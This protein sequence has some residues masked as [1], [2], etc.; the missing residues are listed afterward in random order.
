M[1]NIHTLIKGLIVT[2]FLSVVLALPAY[3]DTN[4]QFLGDKG[5][6]S[7][8]IPVH[9]IPL[10]DEDGQKVS[11]DDEPLLPFSPRQTCGACHNCDEI[12]RGWHFNAIDAN[13]APGRLGQPWILVDAGT[14]TQVPLS[15][16]S[17]RGAFKPN[18]LGLTTWKFNQLFGRHTP[19]GGPG[20]LESDNPDEVVRGF[21]SGKLEINCLSCH[22]AAPAHDQAEFAL[23]IARQNFRWAAAATCGF[24]SVSGS[25]KSM[26]DTYDPLMPEVLDDPKLLPPTINYR[27][28]TFD[29]KKRVFFNIVRKVP[30][31]RCYFC[32]SNMDLGGEE[33]E[34]WSTDEDVHLAAGLTCVDCHRNGLDHN[35]TRG[36]EGEASVSTN[37]LATTS[38]C[39]GCHLG[40]EASSLPTGGRLA[41]PE[42]R[43]AG[44][45]P[46][47]FDKLTCSACHS[48]TWP[49]QQTVRTKTSRA[50]GLGTYS[51]GKSDDALPHIIY[52]VF[53]KQADG[54]IAPHKLIWP[55][56]W[57]SLKDQEVTPIDL[58][59]VRQGAGIIANKAL[60][61]YG[62]W[63]SLTKE[64]VVEGLALASQ[65]SID[66][67]PIYICG[68]K[69]YRL[70][71]KG[72]LIV[73]EHVA[74]NPYL[75]AVAHDV[76]PAAQSLGIAGCRDCH[77]THSPFFFGEVEIDAPVAS[78]KSSVKK[79]IAFQDLNPVY[80]KLFA[81]SFIFRPFLKVVALGSCAVLGV[82]LLLYGLRALACIVR[83][84]SEN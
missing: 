9:L 83:V 78:E 58:E 72:K 55:A 71:G 68:G 74:A 24:A 33:A 43:H 22:D 3:A 17:W 26:P 82:V 23:Q 73:T 69:L 41:A 81:M 15:Y 21:I 48:G 62:D 30:A 39:K 36:Y 1:F 63:P 67:E 76:R 49:R 16:R 32:H 61:R 84:L 6:G 66:G 47:H 25:A 79:M 42:P 13:I 44:I 80:T 5:D 37:L 77:S 14:G 60:P 75:W 20:E 52:P 70:D 64:S 29:H 53:A 45:P 11:P 12:D 57:G 28:N 7:R 2:G 59:I 35:I 34:K 4:E 65:G 51:V 50:H 46:I 54:K 8:S 56:F 10:L 18:Q 40:G 19:G 38:S 31:Q 27:R